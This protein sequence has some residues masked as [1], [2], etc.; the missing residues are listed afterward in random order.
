MNYMTYDHLN[1]LVTLQYTVQGVLKIGSTL[2]IKFS[3]HRKVMDEPSWGLTK[4][5]T[6]FEFS[7]KK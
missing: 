1:I 2:K 7:F 6:K 4:L 5:V 3:T